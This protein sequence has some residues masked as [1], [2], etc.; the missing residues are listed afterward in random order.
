[1]GL[2]MDLIKRY[3]IGAE[4]EHNKITGVCDIFSNGER[5]DIDFRHIQYIE[6]GCIYWRKANMIHK[7][8]VDHCQNGND[9][10][11]SYYVGV[12]SLRELLNTCIMVR[13]TPGLAP[14]LLPTQDGFFFGGTEYDEYYFHDIDYTIKELGKLNLIGEFD[15]FSYYYSS[16]W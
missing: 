7:W 13:D 4:Y 14:E 6:T 12:E 1:M 5:L 2:D 11:K 3:Y 10:C 9:D 16:S 15:D 8:F